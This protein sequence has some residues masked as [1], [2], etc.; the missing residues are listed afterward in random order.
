MQDTRGFTG[1]DCGGCEV[2][3]TG[4]FTLPVAIGELNRCYRD[5][6]VLLAVPV[7]KFGQGSPVIT[8]P[9]PRF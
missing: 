8:E 9:A 7:T 3:E 2:C 4:C 6:S 5:V 1:L